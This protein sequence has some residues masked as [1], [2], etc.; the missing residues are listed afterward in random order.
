MKKTVISAFAFLLCIVLFVGCM[1][2]NVPDIE[3]NDKVTTSPPVTE[4]PPP[5]TTT[6]LS[7]ETAQPPIGGSRSC[8]HTSFG[9]YVDY[10]MSYHAIDGTLIQ[11]VGQEQYEAW[12][13]EKKAEQGVERN[14]E[15][16]NTHGTIYD[17]VKDF[18]FPREVFEALND[19]YL[20][21]GYDYNLD[22]IYS[23]R[24]EAEAYYTSDRTQK[25]FKR[26]SVKRF[27]GKLRSYVKLIDSTA[28][29]KWI[30]RKNETEWGFSDATRSHF[31]IPNMY[32]TY[33]YSD[34]FTGHPAQYGFT[35]YIKEFNIPK[36]VVEEIVT[37]IFV[38][39]DFTIDV[40]RLYSELDS[41]TL[42]KTADGKNIDPFVV[43]E[44]FIV[45]KETTNA[46]V[47]MSPPPETTANN[48]PETQLPIGGSKPCIH[49]SFGEYVNYDM[50]YHAID[51]TLIQY[52]GQDRYEAW[53]KEKRAEQGVERNRERCNTHG[54]IY[55]FVKDF[56]FPREVFE[57]LNDN[58]LRGGYDYNLDVIY[59]SREEAEAYY[60]SDRVQKKFEQRS[61]N[62]LKG[63]LKSYVD[64][65]D[66]TANEKWIARKNGTKWGFSD[67]TRS[68]I[69]IPNMYGTYFYSDEF[70]GFNAQYGFT[71]YIKEFNIPRDVVEGIVKDVFV[72]R[73]FTIDVDRLYS[74]LDSETLFKTADGKNIDPFVVDEQ[75]IVKK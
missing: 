11:Y 73:D 9:E 39:M 68:H 51:G 20:R 32:G 8:I 75:F 24:E 36:S 52:I 66:D 58:Y 46:P 1:N 44:Q 6:S 70:V 2:N 14:R 40:D 54:T 17:F 4:A 74:E 10:D 5:E 13:K 28:N 25:D 63:Q 38:A 53:A 19:N 27:K 30:A 45:K 42:F 29:E 62:R 64:S 41:E 33:F 34:E 61:I 26:W 57:A 18:D 3:T 55:D 59:S 37:D 12:S 21:G 22:V 50:S 23:S 49:T 16:C 72:A 15:R 67:A 43:D 7:T 56:D 47:T 71:E 48:D 60:L 31:K 65:I 35:E 69:K